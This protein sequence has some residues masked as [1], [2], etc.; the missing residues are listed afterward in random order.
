MKCL[1]IILFSSMCRFFAAFPHED[2]TNASKAWAFPPFSV[3]GYFSCLSTIWIWGV[4]EERVRVG[5][6]SP[7]PC[8]N[9]KSSGEADAL[10]LPLSFQ[11]ALIIETFRKKNTSP[12]YDDFGSN[13]FIILL[14]DLC[15]R[16]RV[17]PEQK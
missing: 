13:K 9:A 4:A 15:F 8:R 17:I 2:V 7:I 6:A 3:L 1:T 12:I 14:V 10:N 11:T 5:E 16:L